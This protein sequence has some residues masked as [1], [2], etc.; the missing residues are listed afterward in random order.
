MWTIVEWKTCRRGHKGG[1]GSGQERVKREGHKNEGGGGEQSV[2]ENRIM[3]TN[4]KVNRT[5]TKYKR[6]ETE[7]RERYRE[8]AWPG[9]TC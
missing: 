9:H 7:R 5:L 1:G 3:H 6:R 2:L 4:Y 8:H